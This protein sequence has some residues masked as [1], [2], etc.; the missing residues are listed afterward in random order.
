M[1]GCSAI[2][3]TSQVLGNQRR[4]AKAETDDHGAAG[5]LG[6]YS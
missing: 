4:S 2:L 3:V 6:Y 1:T 5:L